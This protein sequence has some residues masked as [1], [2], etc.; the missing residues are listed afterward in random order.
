M[1][2]CIVLSLADTDTLASQTGI[3]FY[4]PDPSC[5][6]VGCKK[7]HVKLMLKKIPHNMI[8]TRDTN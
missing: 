4:A 2:A 3:E 8:I 1:Y 5:S 6:K 7:R